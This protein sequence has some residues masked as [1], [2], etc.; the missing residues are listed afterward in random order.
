MQRSLIVRKDLGLVQVSGGGDTNQYTSAS[1]SIRASASAREGKEEAISTKII[2][3]NVS[4]RRQ[5]CKWPPRLLA[6]I[7]AL[8]APGRPRE[9]RI[10]CLQPRTPQEPRGLQRLQFYL[11]SHFLSHILQPPPKI[12]IFYDRRTVQEVH[13]EATPNASL[14]QTPKSDDLAEFLAGVCAG[15]CARVYTGAYAGAISWVDCDRQI[16]TGRLRP[17]GRLR[18]VDYDRQIATRLIR[19]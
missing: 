5:N 18:R 7:F 12:L 3:E 19:G 17:V 4:L 13:R 16:A 15:A 14:K 1:N 2:G 8:G 6:K 9:E 11:I 10:R